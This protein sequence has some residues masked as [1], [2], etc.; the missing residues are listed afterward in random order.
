MIVLLNTHSTSGWILLFEA[1]FVVCLLPNNQIK[2]IFLNFC[3][4]EERIILQYGDS[5]KNSLYPI[6]ATCYSNDNDQFSN[7]LALAKLILE[8]AVFLGNIKIF[9][10]KIQVCFCFY[11][12]FGQVACNGGANCFSMLY[13]CGQLRLGD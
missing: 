11:C 8:R 6:V 2:P 9:E 4:L 5:N 10:E 3:F 7:Q 13:F 1:R 12:Y